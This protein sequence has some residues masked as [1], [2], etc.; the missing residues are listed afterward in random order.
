MSRDTKQEE[1]NMTNKTADIILR[2]GTFFTG[3]GKDAIDFIAVRANRIVGMGKKE[4]E[5]PFRGE[6][7]QVL[8][9]GKETLIVPGLHDN[10][11]HLMPAGM[12]AKYLNI[13]DIP[14]EEAAVKAAAD[15]AAEHPDDPWVIGFGWCRFSWPDHKFPTKES[16]DRMIP[17][18]PVLLL[19][20]ELHGAWVNS[21]AL[22]IAGIT[23]ETPDPPYGKIEKDEK[24]EPTGY[25]YETALS[26]AAKYAFDFGEKVVEELIDAYTQ[27]ALSQGITS[28]SD[29]TPYLG[30]DL[31]FESVYMKMEQENKLRIRVNAARDLFEGLEKTLNLRK[32]EAKEAGMYR[33]PYFKQFVDGVIANNTALLLDD[34]LD[35][36]GFK[37]S[38]MLD[39]DA[40]KDAVEQA[41]NAGI[42]V[43]LHA[44][45]DGA[46]SAALD[47]YENA[48][49]KNPQSKCRHQIEHIELIAPQDIERM[50]RLGVIGSVQPEHIVSGIPTFADN[51]YPAQLGEERCRYTWPFRSLTEAGVV[52]AGGSDAPVVEGSPFVGI[53]VGI[54]RVHS[55]GTPENGW[56]PEEKLTAEELLNLYTQGAAFAEGRED[57]L[58]TLE[59][60]KLADIT[61]LDRNILD[62]PSQQIDK[63]RVMLTMVDGKIMYQSI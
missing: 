30:I 42:S 41:H 33:T 6:H 4:E 2:G 43:R 22:K 46:V 54:E 27:Y 51:T 8:E 32:Q 15:Y 24:G 44:C 25:L 50:G 7:T 19:D 48:I 38:P 56:T 23:G 17:D 58:G 52:L 63:A 31:S 1:N 53:R 16:L 5:A 34:Y 37:G 11:I 20:S 61:V 3:T 59:V 40:L 60:G 55:D 9:Y 29:M 21:A 62:I 45:G 14:S 12:L 47:A 18:R 57:E 35:V 13:F 10:H 39:L 28:I 49:R 26:L 36:P